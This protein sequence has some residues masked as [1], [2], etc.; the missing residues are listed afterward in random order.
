[1]DDSSVSKVEKE[2]VFSQKAYLLFYEKVKN[3][4]SDE[5]KE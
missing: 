2:T 4:H 1:M 5:K 3:N